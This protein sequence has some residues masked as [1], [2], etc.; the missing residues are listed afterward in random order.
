MPLPPRLD[1]LFFSLISCVPPSLSLF[2]VHVCTTGVPSFFQSLV[3][4]LGVWGLGFRVWSWVSGFGVW[5]SGFAWSGAICVVQGC[6]Y[7]GGVK[8]FKV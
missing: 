2:L 3:L 6:M 1:F 5:G 7:D 4:G 8:F